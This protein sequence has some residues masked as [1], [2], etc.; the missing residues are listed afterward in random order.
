MTVL[1]QTPSAF[2]Q[3]MQADRDAGDYAEALSLRYVIFGGEELD[4]GRLNDW[5]AR[6]SD[7][8]PVLVNMYGITETTVHVTHAALRSGTA[9]SAL[10]SPIGRGLADLRTHVLD[11][12]LR[13]APPGAVGELYVSGPGMAR[14][15][16]RRPGL[17]SQRFVACPYAPAGSRMYR[18]GDLVRKWPDG[19]LEYVGRADQQVKLRGFRIEPGEIEAVLARHEAVA[20]VA[21]VAREDRPGDRKLVAYVVPHPEGTGTTHAEDEQVGNWRGVYDMLYSD[22]SAPFGEDFS[23]WNSTYDSR[24]IPLE[25]MREWRDATV[26]RIASLGPSRL[27]EIGVGSG[28]LLS[29]LAPGCEAYWGLD[30]SPAAIDKLRAQVTAAGLGN[31][32]KL[33]CRPADALDDLPKG[34]F[35]TVVVNSVAQYFPNADYLTRILRHSLNLLRPG[36]AVF[37]GDV[38]D[39]RSLRGLHTAVEL[40]RATASTDAATLRRAVERSMSLEKELLIDPRF[41]RVFAASTEEVA[42]VDVRLKRARHHNELS[43]H[44]YDVVLYKA[45]ALSVDVSDLPRLQ[46]GRDVGDLA[47]LREMLTERRRS[48]LWITGVPNARVA[49]EFAAARVVWDGGPLDAARGRLADRSAGLD[50]EAFHALG[51]YAGYAVAVTCSAE[52][53]EG[54]FDVVLTDL[55]SWPAQPYAPALAGL[56]TCPA[57]GRDSSATLTNDPTASRDPAAVARSLRGYAAKKLPDFMVP[58]VVVVDKLPLT[59]NGK[60]D[61]TALPRPDLSGQI[62]GSP[63][64]TDAER[65]LCELFA[66]VL[67]LEQ[68]G[69]DDSFFDHGGDSIMAFQLV[70]RG[71][72]AG[73]SFSPQEVFAHPTV[74]ELARITRAARESA[75]TAPAVSGVG[76]VPLTPIV[77]WLRDRNGPIDSFNQSV[78]IRVPAGAGLGRLGAAVQ[79]LLDHHDALRMRLSRQEPW[80]LEVTP[81]GTV[82]ADERVERVDVSGLDEHAMSATVAARAEDSARR[83]DPGTGAMLR[84]V[85]FDAGPERP[86][87]LL[88]VLHHLVVDGVSWR[89]LLPDLRAAWTAAEAG[90]RA[91]LPPV[92][93]AFREWA[94]QLE[95]VAAE[96]ET[97]GELPW[98]EDV[99]ATEDPPLGDR[100]PGCAADGS[101]HVR[102]I[103]VTLPEQYAEPLLTRM[104][105]AFHGRVDDVLLAGLA[106]AVAHWRDGRGRG[107]GSALLVNLEGHGRE[108]EIALGVDLSRTVGWFTT[109][110]PVRLDAGTV[111]WAEVCA[112]GQ[113]AGHVI[114]RVKEQLRAVP[115][116]GIGY[117]LLRYLNPETART[118]ARRPTPQIA[119]NYL[120]RVAV[121]G[122][123][124]W[125]IV[126]EGAAIQTGGPAAQIYGDLPQAHAL[127]INVV[128]VER[129]GGPRLS[130]TWSWMD[131]WLPERDV[132]ELAEAWLATLKGFVAHAQRP[133]SGGHTPSDLPLVSLSQSEIDLLEADLDLELGEW[134]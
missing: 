56:P 69:V 59:P 73:L 101:G 74:A 104:P 111:P 132:K 55:G 51:E 17:T 92:A 10:G 89:I 26:A 90:R 3:L 49:H 21:V 7:Q 125:Q 122:E 50:P 112:G 27:L 117:G 97:I 121:N 24:P 20:Q 44:R 128:A 5:Y 52:D 75:E 110:F 45:P 62:S 61:R 41:F 98:W 102:H 87:R 12:C 114:K 129:A 34:F 42:G 78:L 96:P 83:L 63:P 84:A 9:M 15:Y 58:L 31:R 127:E 11:A 65:R 116:K 76:P 85:W 134:K 82:A 126:E 47:S 64:R 43:Q 16:L 33:H 8:A 103:T 40:N 1:N 68:V 79:S 118:L 131:G 109:I 35:D 71:R 113:A 46:W 70:S 91:E 107:A 37:V 54:C 77:H 13:P 6:H 25:Q 133:E 19:S 66:E 23:G 57:E 123:D 22:S 14:G 39:L 81:P 99:L 119:F 106:T 18:T 38:R 60:L 28:L 124:L 30:L 53:A 130:A 80:R 115:H 95:S 67:G 48:R 94:Q 88:L 36:G 108:E 2:Y 72:E 86:G 29:R 120:G 4:T 32:V 105:A 100:Q 93:T